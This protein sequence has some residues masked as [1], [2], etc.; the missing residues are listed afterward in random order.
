[1]TVPTTRGAPF[2]IIQGMSY[3]H[4]RS[5][6]RRI[7]VR[8]GDRPEMRAS[9]D[10]RETVV[11]MLR[12]HGAAGR[13]TH[14]E[15]EDRTDRAL[16]ARTFGELDAVLKD[17]PRLPDPRRAERRRAMARRAFAEHARMYVRVMV[18]LIVIWAL[19]GADYFWPAWPA[20]GWGIGL[21]AHGAATPR[22]IEGR[23]PRQLGA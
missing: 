7:E 17:L 15:L 23:R 11:D 16:A 6:R 21:L 22:R 1:M 20:L 13:L 14:E 5:P 10:D 2:A 19:T 8:L 18:L 4:Q 12:D 9:D 3:C